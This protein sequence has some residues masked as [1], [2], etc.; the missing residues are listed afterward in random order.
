MTGKTC[1]KCNEKKPF[2]DFAKRYDLVSGFGYVSRCRE[3][4]ATYN[5]EWKRMN[6]KKRRQKA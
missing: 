2:S 4:T 5:R 3:C 1:T 6:G